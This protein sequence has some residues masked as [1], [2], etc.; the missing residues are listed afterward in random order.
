MRL[1]ASFLAVSIGLVLANVAPERPVASAQTPPVPVVLVFSKTAGFRHGSIPAGIAAIRELG[2][3]NGFTVDATEDAGAFTDLNLAR[4]DAVV[5]LSTTGDV[6]NGAQQAAFER[7]IQAG[8]GYVGV[9]AASDTEYTWPWYGKLVGAYFKSHPAVQE[10][11]VRVADRVHPS[12]SGLPVRWVRTDEW[13]DY[14]TS[15]RG[16]IH[17]LATV[18]ERT[19]TGGRSGFDHPIAWCHDYDG[20]RAWYTGGGHTAASYAEP[21]LREHLLGGITWATGESS[22]DCGA[23]VWT[24]Y[25]RVPLDTATVDPLA[26]DVAPDGRVFF[27]ERGGVVKIYKPSLGQ[28][29]VAAR[30]PTYVGQEGGVLGVALDPGFAGNGW[31]YAYYSEPGS[32]PC[33]PADKDATVCGVN[34]LSRFT[35]TGDTLDLA[36][37]R[38]L[39]TVPTQRQVCC[40]EAG[41]LEF[42]PDGN[43]F[44]ATGDNT[45]PFGSD[46]YTPIDE[47]AGRSPWDA[48]RSAANTNDLRGKVLRIHPEADGTYTIPVGN[49]FAVGTARTRPEIYAMGLRNPFRIA[50]DQATGWLFIGDYGPD[51]RTADPR[52]GP[53]ARVEWNLVKVAGN[54]GW[55]FCIGANLPFTDYNFA[56]GVSGVKFS[57]AAPLNRS[58]NNTGLPRLPTARA[59]AVRYSYGTSSVFPELGN[60]C[61]CPMAGPVYDYDPLGTEGK[62]PAYFDGTPLFYDWGRNFIKE[63]RLTP[64]GAL[65]EI[66]DVVPGFTLKRPIDVEFG[67]NGSLYVLEWGTSGYMSNSD[68]GLYRVSYVKGTRAPVAQASADRDAGSVPLA[69]QFSSDGSVDADPGDALTFAW[70]FDSD[71]TTDS[72]E[73][74]PAHT[75]ADAGNYTAKL[76]VTDSTGKTGVANVR[77]AAG[78]T[79]PVVKLDHPVDGGF[80]AFGG[81]LAYAVDV[82]DLEDGTPNCARVVVHAALGHDTHA[83]PLEQYT[84]CEG[85]VQVAEADGHPAAANLFYV[86]EATYED[87]GAPGVARLT[88]RAAHVLQPKRKQAEFFTRS[89]GIRLGLTRDPAGG[90]RNIGHIT[91]GDWASYAPM[92]LL[93]IRSV[94]YRWAS[95]GRGG[96]IEVHVGSPTGPEISDTGYIAPTGG[97]QQYRNVTAPIVDP[98]GTRALFFVFRHKPGADDLFNL[99]WISFNGTGVSFVAA[100]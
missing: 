61:A 85:V 33:G 65:F 98:G 89:R 16:D 67:P 82:A 30:I 80:F 41:S 69:V 40:H 81:Q 29:V 42:G 93:N 34:R 73:A 70:D 2:A 100:P 52:R 10:A 97:W 79:R 54:Y 46:G 38:L 48:Q 17:V 24:N 66:N 35:V 99:N 12:T 90:G 44:L 71:G 59:A 20:G 39:L 23:T 37:E 28:T 50:V 78:N 1:L 53:S 6:L 94:T 75:Y 58:P 77:V 11:T 92:T 87:G 49:L 26:L 96:R 63:F 55:P 9:H 8:G 43:L 76:T 83:H 84:G 21:L 14:R 31:L 91:H 22:G 47:R 51:A 95:A 4:Y 7:F 27:V 74:N 57:C 62:F 72:M 32:S 68:S 5:F 64:S 36:S 13:Y 60:G 3:A 18:D 15:P 19:Y 25:E 56:T 86:L 45:S 88:G